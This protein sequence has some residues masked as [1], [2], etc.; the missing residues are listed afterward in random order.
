MHAIN[1][2]AA[3]GLPLRRGTDGDAGGED[4]ASAG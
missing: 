1:L 4:P 3:Q 2:A